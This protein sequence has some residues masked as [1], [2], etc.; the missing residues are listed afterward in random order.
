MNELV[1]IR[2]ARDGELLELPRKRTLSRRELRRLVTADVDVVTFSP[3]DA[4][5]RPMRRADCIDGERPCPWVSCRHHLALDVTPFG[6]LA[7]TATATASDDELDLDAMTDTCSLDVADR[8][9]HT[10]EEVGEILGVV[11]ERVRQII[12]AALERMRRRHPRARQL[13]EVA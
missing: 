9:D 10:L 1:R 13:P 6:A 11:R 3:D 8:G 2:R 4:P 12:E 5:A 7:L